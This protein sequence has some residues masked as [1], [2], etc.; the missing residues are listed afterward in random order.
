MAYDIHTLLKKAI[1]QPD[2]FFQNFIANEAV[3]EYQ[4][5]SIDEMP[6][7]SVYSFVCLNSEK[8]TDLSDNYLKD[9]EEDIISERDKIIED[10]SPKELTRLTSLCPELNRLL[11]KD[12]WD[13]ITNSHDIED[14]K[15]YLSVYAG[16]CDEFDLYAKYQISLIENC[17]F[18]DFNTVLTKYNNSILFNIDE[19]K[20]KC[21]VVNGINIMWNDIISDEQK[22]VITSILE[23]LEIIG[24]DFV[25]KK[26]ITKKQFYIITNNYSLHTLNRICDNLE[27]PVTVSYYDTEKFV[28]S[29]QRLAS[30]TPYLLSSAMIRKSPPIKSTSKRNFVDLLEWCKSE[31]RGKNA[32]AI[33]FDSSRG[34]MPMELRVSKNAFALFRISILS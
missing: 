28:E 2:M 23:D 30:I 21:H 4:V 33:I 16:R 25:M 11:F 26:P 27:E 34:K 5:V 18:E 20:K 12:E 8:G 19:L 17:F 24:S 22:D 31:S 32:S 9:Y 7:C 6:F 3:T 14:Y 29:L 1:K 13:A 10:V 15:R